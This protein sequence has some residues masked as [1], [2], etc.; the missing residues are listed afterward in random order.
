MRFFSE[1]TN[2]WQVKVL[3]G[4]MVIGM[5]AANPKTRKTVI[6]ALL[7]FVIA[8]EFTN[9]FKDFLPQHRPFQELNN[10]T[11][12]VGTTTHLG[13]ASAHSANMAAIAFVFVYYLRWWGAPWIAIAIVTGISRVFCGA[14]YP[15][16]VLL[17]WICGVVAGV[18]VT[19]GW[20]LIQARRTPKEEAIT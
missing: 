4:I 5:I 10:V 17:G 8:N 18:L 14:H 7:A 20:E 6:Q 12:W 2:Y 13:T 9:L 1:A 15:H 16:Q 3:L 11:M 19:K